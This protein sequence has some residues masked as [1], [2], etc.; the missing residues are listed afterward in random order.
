MV[1]LWRT[2]AGVADDAIAAVVP[3]AVSTAAMTAP[4]MAFL[5]MCSPFFGSPAAEVSTVL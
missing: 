3:A 1:W 4:Q 5:N 2:L